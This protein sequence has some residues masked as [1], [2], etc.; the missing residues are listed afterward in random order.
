M[1]AITP[2]VSEWFTPEVFPEGARALLHLFY[3]SYD[4]RMFL[5]NQGQNSSIAGFKKNRKRNSSKA[6]LETQLVQSLFTMSPETPLNSE[7]TEM[8]EL[9]KA[10]GEE[11]RKEAIKAK[12]RPLNSY[13]TEEEK[14]KEAA[15]R[16][17][18][19]KEGEELDEVV[20]SMYGL[21]EKIADI[22]ESY[23]RQYQFSEITR[24]IRNAV[25]VFVESDTEDDDEFGTT[26]GGTDDF[27]DDSTTDENDTNDDSDD[28]EDY[29]GSD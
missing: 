6:A 3:K 28:Q 27:D 11:A 24:R 16:V 15:R 26:D 5:R 19:R 25:Q 10:V 4:S 21:K 20:K 9:A 18:P 23:I 14:K 2:D 8:Q 22:E 7:L 12:N 13:F 29:S 1:F 17:G